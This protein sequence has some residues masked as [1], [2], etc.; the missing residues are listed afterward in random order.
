MQMHEDSNIRTASRQVKVMK[1]AVNIEASAATAASGTESRHSS[2]ET[3]AALHTLTAEMR[4][5]PQAAEIS[6]T[7]TGTVGAAHH[8]TG[9]DDLEVPTSCLAMHIQQQCGKPERRSRR[10]RHL[11]GGC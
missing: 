8:T 4:S 1:A 9:E 5:M 10:R 7:Y 11:P 6:A 2:I 3:G